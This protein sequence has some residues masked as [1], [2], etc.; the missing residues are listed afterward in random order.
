MDINAKNN[1]NDATLSDDIKNAVLEEL[2]IEAR[3]KY[4]RDYY[5]KN[6][7]H[8]Q[9]RLKK[10]R[11]ANPEKVRKATKKWRK[12]NPEKVRKIQ[13]DYYLRKI[14][15]RM[16]DNK[17]PVEQYNK[18]LEDK[19]AMALDLLNNYTVGGGD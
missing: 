5:I 18:S 19:K 3:R 13:H 12:A 1:L 16:S 7:E 2:V 10:W 11:D 17:P 15:E 4:Y 6:K 8:I 14:T 9:Q